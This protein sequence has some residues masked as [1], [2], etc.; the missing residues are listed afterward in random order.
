MS[1]RSRY[2]IQP[3]KGMLNGWANTPFQ[4]NNRNGRIARA[5]RLLSERLGVEVKARTLQA[6]LDGHN[7]PPAEIRLGVAELFG[8][9][10]AECWTREV[11]AATYVGPRGFPSKPSTAV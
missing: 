9:D 4:R 10:P 3:A 11:L 8:C 6:Y 5:S 7:L 1:K 2:G